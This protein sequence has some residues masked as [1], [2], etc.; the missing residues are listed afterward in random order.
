MKTAQEQYKLRKEAFVSNHTGGSIGEINLVTAIA[1]VGCPP[2]HRHWP[3]SHRALVRQVTYAVFAVL[4]TRLGLFARYGPAQLALDFALTA[5]ALLLATTLYASQ[6]LLLNV[7]ALS[8]AVLV[9]LAAPRPA[10]RAVK[11]PKPKPDNPGRNSNEK[12]SQGQRTEDLLPRKAFLAVYRGSLMLVTCVA[13]LAVD[14]PV[15]PRRFAKVE[16]WGT[17]LM[18]MG[19]GSF[20]FSSGVVS[21]RP[22]VKQQLLRLLLPRDAPSPVPSPAARLRAAMR[23]ALPLL[24]LGLVRLAIVKGVDYAEHVTEYGVH[25]NFFFTL[26]LLPPFVALLQSLPAVGG[27]SRSSSSRASPTVYAALALLVAGGYQCVLARTGLQE[28]VLVGDR[29]RYGLLGLNKEGASSFAGYLAIF[30]AG[31][32]AGTYVLPRRGPLRTMAFWALFWSAACWA[33][34]A[35]GRGWALGLTVSRRLANLP[36]FLWVNAFNSAQLVAFYLVERLFFSDEA[37]YRSRVPWV[38]HAFNRNG[39]PVF[40]IVGFPLP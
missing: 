13:I 4:Q 38:L 12:Q 31:M 40:L 20:V 3:P 35:Y 39:L 7:L 27:S 26:G 8:P 14:F 24:A 30:L 36:Y 25:W 34:T 2:S 18:D 6:P 28:F 15:F 1:P 17:S 33:A 32:S 21:A 22:L 19:V 11:R 23:T 29:H 16:N 5:G 9:W 37:S 10:P